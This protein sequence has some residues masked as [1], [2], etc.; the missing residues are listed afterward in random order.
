MKRSLVSLER[1]PQGW[2]N[3]DDGKEWFGRRAD[4]FRVLAHAHE[5]HQREQSKK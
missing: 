2:L 4:A 1:M 3:S 5:K